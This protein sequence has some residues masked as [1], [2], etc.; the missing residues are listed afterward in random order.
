MGIKNH[1]KNGIIEVWEDVYD[2][3]LDDKAAPDL[4]DIM[5]GEEESF[6]SN[7]EEFFKRTYMTKS[8][9]ELI[10]DVAETLKGGKGGGIFLLT[11]LFGGGKT[12]TQICL[13]HT[14]KNPEK[15]KVINENLS[16]KVAVSGKPTIIIMDASRAELVP[17]P[18]EPYK[19]EG[20]TIKTIWG[21]LA[22]RLG[23]YAKIK[24][25][26]NEKAPAPDVNLIKSI[27][28]EVREP[29]LILMDEIVHYVFNM[30]KSQSLRD[31]SGKVLLFLDYLARAVE[32]TPKIVLVTSV[33][34]EYRVVE[35]Q[36][37][38]MEEEVFR[39]YAGKVLSVLSREST[40]II[41]PVAADDVVLVLQKRIFK[42]ITE[43]EAWNARDRL[44]GAFRQS[45][46]LFGVESDWQY[47]PSEAGR[48]VTIKDTYPFHIK[49][50]EV[51][52]EFVTRNRD[53]QK[54]RDAI[55]ITRKVVRRFLRGKE[56][57][58][59]I[60]PWHIDFR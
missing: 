3:R 5:K 46:E 51:L 26:D 47:S 21:M 25:L 44:Y 31:Y 10:E 20:F 49:Y 40:R 23:A 43:S 11:S 29:V 41:V 33:Q 36:K 18:Q 48:V 53:L 59:F 35:G 54:T 45:P 38:L 7:P 9:E 16:A 57:T 27:F 2:A 8:I 55:R 30:E 1:I 39:G 28:S 19:T 58:D 15:L 17:H 34:A 14:F 12:H 6:Y 37:L 24:H 56:D 60:M 13:Y 22:Y 50:V 52:Q 42:K 4:S 32:S